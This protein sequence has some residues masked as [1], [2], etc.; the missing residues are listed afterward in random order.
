MIV[1]FALPSVQGAKRVNRSHLVYLKRADFDKDGASGRIWTSASLWLFT[2]IGSL[3][4]EDAE[5]A[6]LGA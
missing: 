3:W 6:V 4:V 5:Y 1:E 2:W